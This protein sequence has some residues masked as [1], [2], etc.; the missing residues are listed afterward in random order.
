MNKYLA[1]IIEWAAH[2]LLAR[3]VTRAVQ[4]IGEV[5]DNYA[6]QYKHLAAPVLPQV[7]YR[8]D[9]GDKVAATELPVAKRP[10]AKR[11]RAA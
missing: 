2:K 10:A 7:E 1:N 8:M 4:I 6:K 11:L 9:R 5:D 3:A